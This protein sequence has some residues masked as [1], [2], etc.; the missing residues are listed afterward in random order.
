[1]QHLAHGFKQLEHLIERSE[2]ILLI[3]HKKPDGDT[4]GA[5]TALSRW[6]RT[7]GKTVSIFCLNLP[8]RTF[9]YIHEVQHYT[10]NPDVFSG[11]FDLVI[12]IDSGDLKYAGVDI[13]FP[14][15]IPGYTLVNIDHHQTN[16]LYGNLN[17]VAAGSSSTCE[18]MYHFFETNKIS[19]DAEIATS[20]L[21]GLCTDTSN[22]SNPLTSES[23]LKAASS[24][25]A[26]GGRFTDILRYLWRNKTF[27]GLKAWGKLLSRLSYNQTYDIATTYVLE[28]ELAGAPP[29]QYDTFVNFLSGVL[30]GP[31]TILFLKEDAGH[32]IR[33]SFRGHKRDVSTFA[34][35]FGG[36]GHKGAAGFTVNGRMILDGNGDIRIEKI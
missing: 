17:L 9:R 36:G 12:V 28:E 11:K 25:V 30:K 31:D 23:S 5:T 13:F 33:G 20:L 34:K 35:L 8:A 27:D 7:Q 1:M 16:Q 4:T 14:Q 3:S 22:F 6:C 24:L 10:T 18:V 29:E 19:I 26:Q 21:T 2:R 15:L 32:V